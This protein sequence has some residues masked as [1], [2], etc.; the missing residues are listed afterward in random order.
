[1]DLAFLRFNI[2][3][4]YITFTVYCMYPEHHFPPFFLDKYCFIFSSCIQ[5]SAFGSA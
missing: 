5:V 4:P 3:I 2:H 1:M